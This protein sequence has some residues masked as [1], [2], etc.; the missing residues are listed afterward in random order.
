M[1]YSQEFYC[2]NYSNYQSA[3]DS[4]CFIV[5]A[6]NEL[7]TQ[8]LFHLSPE[9]FVTGDLHMFLNYFY[10]FLST[11]WKQLVKSYWHFFDSNQS[12]PQ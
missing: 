8:I 6:K 5:I 3:D 7:K 11:Y 4:A 9:A 2:G 1:E 10:S 12:H